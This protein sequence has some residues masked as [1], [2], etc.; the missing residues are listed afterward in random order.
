MILKFDNFLK[1]SSSVPVEFAATL[2]VNPPTAYRMLKDF[3][4]LRPGDTVIQNGANSAVGQAVIQ[5]AA[6]WGVNTIN[7]VRSRYEQAYIYITYYDSYRP[8]STDFD[9]VKYLKDIGATEVVTEEY[10]HSHQMKELMKV[11][12]SLSLALYLNVLYIRIILNH[13]LVLIVWAVK[14]QLD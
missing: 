14:A 2:Q 8:E 10:L 12:A 3:V 7:V 1:V 6:A 4:N 5:L 13:P 11:C 9:V